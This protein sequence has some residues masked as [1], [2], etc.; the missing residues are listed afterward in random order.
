M[1]DCLQCARC[2]AVVPA[3]RLILVFANH[4]QAGGAVPT[5]GTQSAGPPPTTF[6][7]ALLR[8]ALSESISCTAAALQCPRLRCVCWHWCQPWP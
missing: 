4:V 2:A 5:L 3:N 1:D 6:D 8:E 7:Q